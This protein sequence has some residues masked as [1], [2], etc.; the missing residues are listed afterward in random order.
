[1]FVDVFPKSLFAFEHER[2]QCEPL[3]AVPPT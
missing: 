2:P 3:F 1:M